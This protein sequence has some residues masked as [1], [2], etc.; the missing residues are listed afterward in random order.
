MRRREEF[1]QLLLLVV[2][3][4]HVFLFA[5]QFLVPVT[6]RTAVV[7][8]AQERLVLPLSSGTSG[9]A[10]VVRRRSARTAAERALSQVSVGRVQAL[11]CSLVPLSDRSSG[12]GD[13]I[14]CQC[15]SLSVFDALFLQLYADAA[16]D[17][18]HEKGQHVSSFPP[19]KRKA[20][21]ANPVVRATD[22]QSLETGWSGGWRVNAPSRA[23]G[24]R[25]TSLREYAGREIYTSRRPAVS[26]PRSASRER[27]PT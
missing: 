15:L 25:P 17:D 2:R 27:C 4:R 23:I 11:G 5:L 26:S 20:E 1:G 9:L 7:D 14:G 22:R 8:R 6:Q 3:P 21:I 10:S 16:R 24:V 19:L 12:V 13:F 18:A